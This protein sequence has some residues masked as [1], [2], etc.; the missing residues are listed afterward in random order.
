MINPLL[1]LFL[2]LTVLAP[3]V[4]WRWVT[5]C[6]TRDI[7]HRGWIRGA[8]FGLAALHWPT[9]WLTLHGHV[10]WA[11]PL[12]AVALGALI[13]MS[14]AAIPL[15]LVQFA[16]WLRRWA[17]RPIR[18]NAAPPEPRRRQL[19]EA[20]AGVAVL[21]LTGSALGW[22]FIKGRHDYELCEV[23]VRIPGLP[24]ALDGYVITQLSDIHTGPFVNEAEL[25]VS[26]SLVTRSKPDLICV[27]GD[28]VDA[29]ARW[30]PLI[31][32]RLGG[33]KSR[34][35]VVAVLG[36]H[37]HYA[38]W[39]SVASALR[40]AGVELLLNQGRVIRPRDGGGFALLGVDDLSAIDFG[41]RGPDL[42]GALGMVPIDLPRIL[43]SHRPTTVDR[44]AG[45]VALQLSGHTHGGQINPGSLAADLLFKYVAG[46]YVVDG[47][48][49]YVNRGLGTG[50]PPSRIG[51]RPE[52]TRIVLIS[53]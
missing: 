17:M 45:Q 12:H 37:D 15:G 11:S 41:G 23:P 26:L 43:L 10:G 8:L 50:G 5:R 31:A 35:G 28:L 46:R 52:V 9:G 40:D 33:L 3:L 2:A 25:N 13:S 16:S 36:N 1:P 44:W 47:T 22:G 20:G 42:N 27:T 34:D 49:L 53:A 21:S 38:G 14:L 18:P 48:T 30:A 7:R 6:L 19:L 4:I 51:A 32:A 24:R 29:E 39:Q